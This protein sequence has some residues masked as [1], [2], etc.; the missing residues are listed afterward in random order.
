MVCNLTENLIE[1]SGIRPLSV[2][3][4]PPSYSISSRRSVF[5]PR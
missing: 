3:L 4:V 5:G 2:F 1:L